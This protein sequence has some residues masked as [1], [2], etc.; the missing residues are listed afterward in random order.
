MFKLYLIV[1]KQSE[2]NIRVYK[3][4]FKCWHHSGSALTPPY[5]SI[6]TLQ[7]YVFIHWIQQQSI[8]RF[9]SHRCLYPLEPCISNLP[10][11]N[12]AWVSQS[13]S[14]ST[15][16]RLNYLSF[17]PSPITSKPVSCL[18]ALSK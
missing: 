11:N 16:L 14:K 4:L 6:Y 1:W 8:H 10:L 13:T 5:F 17:L 18:K 3:Y 7:L 12:S 15:C 2:Q 9:Q